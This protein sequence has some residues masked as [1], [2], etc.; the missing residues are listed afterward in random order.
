MSENKTKATGAS[1]EDFLENVPDE[2]R[3]ADCRRVCEIMR[4]AAGAEPKLWGA[5]MVGF[6]SYHYRYES[7]REGDWFITGFS[8]RKND[9]T[10]YIMAGFTRYPDLMARLGK[11]RTGKSCLYLRK[12]SDVDLDV[13]TELVTESVKHVR[14]TYDTTGE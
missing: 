11:H 12:L 6:G 13:L 5:S 1:V 4:K 10:L 9:L 7:G 14:A 3:R 2:Q 8:P